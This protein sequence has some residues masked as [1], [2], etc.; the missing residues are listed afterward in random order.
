MVGEPLATQAEQDGLA[1][2]LLSDFPVQDIQPTA[3]IGNTDFMADNPEAAQGFVTAYLRASRDL[4]GDGF[5]D[6]VNLAIIEEYTGV[7]A[8][9]IA[10]AVQPLLQPDGDIN[11]GQLLDPADLLPR[12]R[13][14]RVRRRP[15]PVDASSTR[16]TSTP[17]SPRLA[18]TNRR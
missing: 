17:R 13:P 11:S 3:I 18:P 6:P 14:T 7:P 16:P 8:T 5:N 15:R 1:V 9:L 12:A 4:T 2:R 10:A